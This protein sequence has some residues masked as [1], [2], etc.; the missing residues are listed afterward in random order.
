MLTL[1]YFPV[2]PVKCLPGTAAR[3]N[4]HDQ[5]CPVSLDGWRQFVTMERSL[6]LKFKSRAQDNR[7]RF[8][9]GQNWEARVGK[10]AILGWLR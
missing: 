1:R 3:C 5:N 8:E 7:M 9:M 4:L 2:F 10:P 6:S